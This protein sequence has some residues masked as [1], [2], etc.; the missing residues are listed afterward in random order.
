MNEALAA[1]EGGCCSA[2]PHAAAH[3]EAIDSAAEAKIDVAA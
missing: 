2:C 3:S 1:C